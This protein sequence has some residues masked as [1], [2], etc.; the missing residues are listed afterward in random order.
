MKTREEVLK[1]Y[2]KRCAE[3]KW[4]NFMPH[5][6]VCRCGYDF[7]QANSEKLAEIFVSGCPRCNKSYC[8]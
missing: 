8:S 1:A 7:Y 6:G 3:N 5:R 2:A 4:W